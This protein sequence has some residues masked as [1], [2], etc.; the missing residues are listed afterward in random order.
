MIQ[1]VLFMT[2]FL[3]SLAA[4]AQAEVAVRACREFFAI[5]SSPLHARMVADTGRPDRIRLVTPLVSEEGEASIW[6]RLAAIGTVTATPSNRTFETDGLVFQPTIPDVTRTPSAHTAMSFVRPG[7]QPGRVV[8]SYVEIGYALHVTTETNGDGPGRILSA[9]AYALRPDRI[10][11]FE[12]LL[13]S[14]E[15][16][17]NGRQLNVGFRG[18]VYR[19]PWTSPRFEGR[20]QIDVQEGRI[21]L[22]DLRGNH[23]SEY[24]GLVRRQGE[25]TYT[26]SYADGAIAVVAQVSVRAQGR[27]HLEEITMTRLDSP[28][29]AVLVPPYMQPVYFGY[30]PRLQVEPS[31]LPR[32][33]MDPE[34]STR[35]RR[36][37]DEPRRAV[38]VQ[39]DPA[40]RTILL[41]PTD[42]NGNAVMQAAGIYIGVSRREGDVLR[43]THY[44]GHDRVQAL[45]RETSPGQ[46][47]IEQFLVGAFGRDGPRDVFRSYT[48]L[49]D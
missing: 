32:G 10:Q 30:L 22:F 27:L 19:D 1:S 33:F 40:S 21:S 43:I 45:L 42:Q 16:T 14:D 36:S 23:T 11:Q 34:F 24:R 31:P 39:I 28:T 7:L 13:P 12:R 25:S 4:S 17:T 41:A 9:V 35:E 46:F 5:G 6:S 38:F 26:V 37:Q 20:A 29:N 2:M 8:L 47:I 49:R 15:G 48:P 3:I 44:D 18:E